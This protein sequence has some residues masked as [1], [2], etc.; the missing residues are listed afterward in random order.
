MEAPELDKQHPTGERRQLSGLQRDRY[1][2]L[3]VASNCSAASDAASAGSPETS[4]P[5]VLQRRSFSFPSRT[6]PVTNHSP[7]SALRWS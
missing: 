1:T 5:A 4:L 3:G 7:S 6:A 2:L